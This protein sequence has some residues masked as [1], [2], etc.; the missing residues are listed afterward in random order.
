ML[1]SKL[2]ELTTS[3]PTAYEDFG[4]HVVGA[5]IYLGLETLKNHKVG[6]KA[7]V[8]HPTET[9]QKR[10]GLALWLT[11]QKVKVGTDTI[12]MLLVPLTKMHAEKYKL[13]GRMLGD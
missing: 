7:L 6:V 5:S 3:S 2:I 13:A 8:N 4:F 9:Q 12:T 1:P 10:L 11:Q